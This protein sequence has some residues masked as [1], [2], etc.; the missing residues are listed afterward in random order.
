MRRTDRLFE[1]VQK[2]RGGRLRRGK[3]LAAELSIS[4]RTLYRDIETLVASGIPIEGE[5]GVGYQLRQPI[6]LPPLNLTATE[7]EALQFGLALGSKAA[8][9]ELAEASQVLLDKIRAVLPSASAVPTPNPAMVAYNPHIGTSLTNLPPLRKAIK[10]QHKLEIVY[11]SPDGVVSQRTIWPLQVEY[12]GQVWT[13]TTW[14][15]RRND[16]RVFRV[17]RIQHLKPTTIRFPQDGSYLLA[18]FLKR[19]DDLPC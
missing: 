16:F 6:F 11:K 13:C 8:D 7:F 10:A 18:Q 14:C 2:F 19:F 15:E 9:P 17:D 4:L 5:R 1:L 12:W 3:D